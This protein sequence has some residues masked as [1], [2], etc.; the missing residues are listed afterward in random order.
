MEYRRITLL[1]GH[2]GSGKTNVAVNMAEDLKR[3]EER[4][5]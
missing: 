1:S 2:Y 3:T 4:A 5:K